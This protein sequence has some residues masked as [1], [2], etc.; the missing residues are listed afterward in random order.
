MARLYSTG[1]ANLYISKTSAGSSYNMEGLLTYPSKVSTYFLGT[2]EKPPE[3]TIEPS[4]LPIKADVGGPT[5]PFDHLFMGE[6]GIVTGVLNKFNEA[7]Y[8]YITARPNLSG[9]RGAYLRQD[10]G[11]PMMITGPGVA[12]CLWV[13]FPYQSKTVY[14]TDGSMPKAYRFP[15]TILM[16]PD[17]IVPGAGS[18]RVLSFWCGRVYKKSDGTWTV[19]DHVTVDPGDATNALPAV[20]PITADGV[21]FP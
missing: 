9:T 20:P 11:R 6:I 1:P 10:I 3:I 2:C 7:V 18:R 21:V 8:S 14:G 17:Q 12:F 4:F 19:Y 5:L 15:G 16:G 13:Q